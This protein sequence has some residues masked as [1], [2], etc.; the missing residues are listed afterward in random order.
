MGRAPGSAG[1]QARRVLPDVA[2]PISPPALVRA[3]A[4]PS[5]PW[6]PGHR[7]IDL[8]APPGAPVRAMAPGIVAF[9]GEVGGIGVVTID[10]GGFHST[11]Q[12]IETD[13]AVGD[14]VA[15]GSVIG[16]TASSGEPGGHCAGRCLHL[17]VLVGEDYMDPLRLLRRIAVLKPLR[18]AATPP[19]G[20]PG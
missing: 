11:Y 14:A 20:A 18:P 16:R 7:G 13:R 6:G 2:W 17:G 1:R 12:P 9:A 10:H 15:T 3:F 4:P 19:A 5:A 8:A